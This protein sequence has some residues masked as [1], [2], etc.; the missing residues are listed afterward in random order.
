MYTVLNFP[1]YMQ[2]QLEEDIDLNK[3]T[4]LNYDND[5][6]RAISSQ[7]R[8]IPGAALASL[9]IHDDFHSSYFVFANTAY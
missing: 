1:E 6:S 9:M 2:E 5:I 4:H 7:E 8:T 3:L